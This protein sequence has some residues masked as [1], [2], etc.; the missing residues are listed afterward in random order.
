VAATV[1]HLV[2][3]GRLDLQDTVGDWLPGLDHPNIAPSITV[4]QLLNH[5]AGT[6]NFGDDPEFRQALFADWARYWQP[7]DALNY[8]KTPY[9]SPNADGQYSNTGYVLLGMIIRSVTGSTVAEGIRRSVQE[10]LALHSTFLGGEESWIGEL[11]HPHL[12]FNGDGVH[13]D[14]GG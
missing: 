13:E 14:L 4:R 11:A 7:E 6:Y 1:L 3:E 8:V 9:F 10:R 2:E 5:R 12:D